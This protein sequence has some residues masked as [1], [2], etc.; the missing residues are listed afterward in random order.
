MF[1]KLL[2]K[3]K[4][5][6]DILAVAVYGSFARGEKHRDIDIC[7][8][9]YPGKPRNRKELEYMKLLGDGYDVHMFQE[10]P[11]YIRSRVIKEGRIILCKDDSILYD[12]YLD[13]IREY[14]LFEPHYQTYL[15]AV[16]RNG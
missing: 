11:I 14:S 10:L 6:R 3:A 15:H 2:E 4:S 1:E 8:I 13:T 5:D 16:A 12:L 7:L 9:P